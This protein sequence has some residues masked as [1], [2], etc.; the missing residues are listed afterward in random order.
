[1]QRH[2]EQMSLIDFLMPDST[3]IVDVYNL[4]FRSWHAHKHLNQVG[5][6][7]VSHIFGSLKSIA[8]LRRN[9]GATNLHFVTDGYPQWRHDLLPEYKGNRP[10][11]GS[12]SGSDKFAGVNPPQEVIKVLQLLPAAWHHH[13][14]EEAD[15][16]IAS[17]VSSLDQTTGAC[18]IA[19]SDRDLWALADRK[20]TI[21]GNKQKKFDP[22]QVEIELKVPP[23]RV[24]LYKAFFGDASD[25]IKG[26]PRIRKTKLIPLIRKFTTVGEIYDHI[27]STACVVGLSKNEVIKLRDH[28]EIVDTNFQVVQLRR[29][30]RYKTTEYPGDPNTLQ[31][32]LV[33]LDCPSLLKDM[34]DLFR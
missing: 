34:D 17:L 12:S 33:E 24:A 2:T 5:K 30:V 13:P 1:M 7:P 8:S 29:N 26:V 22:R 23:E 11:R 4:A 27:F 9:T 10:S 28:R 20:V 31:R 25:N 19:T 32:L 18:W 3:L 21:L 14:D 15:D 6:H 16:V